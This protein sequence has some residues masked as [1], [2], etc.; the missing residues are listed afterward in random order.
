[1][2]SYF[3]LVFA[4]ALN[5]FRD[6]MRSRFFTLFAIFAFVLLYA[7]TLGSMLAVSHE[8]RVLADISLLLIELL[9][10]IYAIFQVSTTLTTEIQNKTIYLVL[11]R[12]VPR[13]ICL[14]GKE[15]G[16]ILTTGAI[17]IMLALMAALVI[18]TRSLDI[19]P[20]FFW[21]V[22]GSFIKVTIIISF[23]FIMS[24]ISTSNITSFIVAALFYVLGH[25][26]AQIQPLMQKASGLRLLLLKF[27]A[28][29]FPNLNLYS[30]RETDI[31]AFPFT[32]GALCAALIWIIAAYLMSAWLFSKK[33]L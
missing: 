15:L 9:C 16:V 31:T 23:A 7:S 28:I 11:A 8:E 4:L 2:T 26:T 25:V 14:L 19:P 32:C 20:L 5:T 13:A 30:V 21:A 6:S 3:K 22:C 24:L 1:M 12:P 27:C 10:L 33:E 18:K 17:S 29:I